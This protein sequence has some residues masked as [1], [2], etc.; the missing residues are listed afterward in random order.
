LLG[1]IVGE[2]DREVV[3]EGQDGALVF[4]EAIEKISGFGLFGATAAGRARGR[5][6]R[7]FV[8]ALSEESLI[9]PEPGFELMGSGSGTDRF[10][11]LDELEHFGE[12]RYHPRGPGLVELF[13]EENQFS[14]VMSVAEA[15]VAGI[16][17]VG[18]KTIVDEASVIAGKDPDMVHGE[19][20]AFGMNGIVGQ[21]RGGGAVK[22]VKSSCDAQA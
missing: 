10:L 19:V 20:A 9:A 11:F 21:K 13:V 6:R 3:E 12:Q 15:V 17:E 22:P 7:I 14:Q 16:T 5:Q 1:L 18:G 8:T 2:R 4:L